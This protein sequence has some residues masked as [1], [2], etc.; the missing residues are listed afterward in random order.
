MPSSSA[1]SFHA[2]SLLSMYL[3]WSSS[4]SYS[5]W[6]CLILLIMTRSKLVSLA[7]TIAAFIADAVD[8]AVAAAFVLLATAA[9]AAAVGGGEE[10]VVSAGRAITRPV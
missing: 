9:T 6:C 5:T 2:L 1:T 10:D 3:Y 7:N 4:V 8:E